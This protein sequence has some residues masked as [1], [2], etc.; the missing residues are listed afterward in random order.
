MA[1]NANL[2][3]LHMGAICSFDQFLSCLAAALHDL[4]GVALEE[5]LADGIVVGVVLRLI[6]WEMPW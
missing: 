2:G 5:D 6:V 1:F 3:D 4:F